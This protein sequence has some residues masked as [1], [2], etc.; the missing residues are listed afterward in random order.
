MSEFCSGGDLL[1]YVNNR[2]LPLHESD[3]FTIAIQ[4]LRAIKYIHGKG[5]IHAD[6]KLEN[7]LLAETDSIEQLQ[8]VDFGL[9]YRKTHVNDLMKVASGTIDYMA[10]EMLAQTQTYDVQC[11]MWSIGVLLFILATGVMPFAAAS[12]EGTIQLILLPEAVTQKR[13]MEMPQFKAL[14]P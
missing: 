4:V 2:G 12:S 7:V 10:P 11:D 13:F 5:I 3:V 6:I 9:S 14:T 8:I 1:G